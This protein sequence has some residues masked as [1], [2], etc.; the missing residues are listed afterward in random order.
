MIPDAS[1]WN[2]SRR[3]GG[4]NVA[5]PAGCGNFTDATFC[6]D[7]LPYYSVVPYWDQLHIAAGTPQGLY[8]QILDPD[9]YPSVVFEW[10]TSHVD[11]S[12]EYYHFTLQFFS[13]YSDWVEIAYYQIADRGAGGTVGLQGAPDCEFDSP[14]RLGRMSFLTWLI[15]IEGGIEKY[16]Q[17]SQYSYNEPILYRGL[18][19]DWDPSNNTWTPYYQHVC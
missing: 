18:V 17:Y 1:A 19:L 3:L 5:I 8:Y 4:S 11:N 14:L 13:E 12:S 15:A 2:N 6:P 9:F 16:S 7:G 10:Y